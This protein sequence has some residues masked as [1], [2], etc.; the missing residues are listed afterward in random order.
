V[1]GDIN[2]DGKVTVADISALMTALS[3]LSGYRS[4]HSGMSDPIQFMEVADVNNDTQVNNTD[5]Q[6]LISLVANNASGGGGGQL[7]AVPE[8][9][10]IVLLGL[11]ALAFAFRRRSQAT[12]NPSNNTNHSQRGCRADQFSANQSQSISKCSH[13]KCHRNQSD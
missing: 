3:D 7:T 6:A 9:G 10:S 5:I 11:G 12:T 4:T 1:P 2:R 13:V 8:P